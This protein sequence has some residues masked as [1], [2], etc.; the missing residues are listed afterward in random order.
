MPVWHGRRARGAKASDAL[1]THHYM[2]S[3]STK[4]TLR[5]DYNAGSLTLLQIEN[6]FREYVMWGRRNKHL[7][8]IKFKCRSDAAYRGGRQK[9]LKWKKP[10]LV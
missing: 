2:Y 6:N 10:L 1:L 3:L 8:F 9:I 7:A 4:A 5:D